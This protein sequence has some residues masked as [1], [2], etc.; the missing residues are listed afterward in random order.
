MRYKTRDNLVAGGIL[1]GFGFITLLIIASVLFVP[2]GWIINIVWLVHHSAS[3]TLSSLNLDEIL[4]IVGVPF[5]P[6]GAIM[7]YFG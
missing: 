3:I 7:G 4:R 5:A 2:I 6:L 1:G